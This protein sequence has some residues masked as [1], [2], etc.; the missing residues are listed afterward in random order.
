MTTE[1]MHAGDAS[2]NAGEPEAGTLAHAVAAIRP[3]FDAKAYARAYRDLAGNADEL[4]RHFCL[5][6]WQEGRNPHGGFDTMAYLLAHPDVAASGANPFYHYLQFG[7]QEGRT[8]TPASWPAEAA[9]QL[10]GHDPGDWVALLRPALDAPFYAARLG[11]SFDGGFDLA[12]HFAYRGW[13]EGRSP[14]PGFDVQAA[15]DARP[16]LRQARVNPL[17]AQMAGLSS[18]QDAEPGKLQT[19][20]FSRNALSTAGERVD[21]L[22]PGP[23]PSYD[24]PVEQLVAGQM[25]GGF[26]LGMYDDIRRAGID[27]VRHYCAHGWTEGRDPAAWFSTRYYLATNPDVAGHGLNPFWHYLNFGRSEGRNPSRPGG[28]LRQTIEDAVDPDVITDAYAP[29]EITARLTRVRLAALLRPALEATAGLVL[30]AGHD[31]YIRVTGGIQLFIANE[32]AKFAR[33]NL[34]YLNVSPSR[35]LLRL[36]DP[37]TAG[38]ALTLI[39]DG[40]FLGVASATDLAAV[41]RRIPPRPGE[42][43]LF[44]VHCLLGHSMADLAALHRASL[45]AR[46]VFWVHDYSSICVGYTL[47]RNDAAFC[48]APPLG[49]MACRVCVYGNRREGHAGQ[50]RALFEAIPFEVAAPS[51]TALTIWLAHAALPYMVARAHPHCTLEADPALPCVRPAE[52]PVRVAFIGYPRPQKG[53]P[54]WRQLIARTCHTGAYKFFHLG[55]AEAIQDLP[56]MQCHQVSTSPEQP[57]A[58][59]QALAELGIDLVAMLSPWPETFSY[60]AHEALAAGVDLVCLADSGNIAAVVLQQGRGAVAAD[61]A[62]LIDFFKSLEAVAYVKLC[63]AQ[64]TGRSRLVHEGTTASL[65]EAKAGALLQL[66]PEDDRSLGSCS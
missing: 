22:Q 15:L 55:S 44:V 17:I 8:V 27:P 31:R 41:L 66:P 21:A 40:C 26:Y 65:G 54:L 52:T 47:L 64:G 24:D 35:P 58:M 9:M 7:E 56:G 37:Q 4:L 50:V 29:P 49:S 1:M 18:S 6:G 23:T 51:E 53:W 25:D 61:E 10:L 11:P 3:R 43:R 30:S 2:P 45:A 60:A 5:Q 20:R 57:D 12:A 14:N 32:Q 13:L 48:H 28:V 16:Q 46:A 34:A 38:L 59:T 63:R 36:A 62:S 33:Q 42:Q 39:L 19:T